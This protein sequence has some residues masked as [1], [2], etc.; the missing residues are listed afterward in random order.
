[1]LDSKES[2][3]FVWFQSS[4]LCKKTESTPF[5]FPDKARSSVT[6]PCV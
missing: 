2:H 3:I 1:M 4:R 6:F 5:R